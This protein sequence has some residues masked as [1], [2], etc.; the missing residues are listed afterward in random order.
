[1]VADEEVVVEQAEGA[2][3][4]LA[5]EAHVLRLDGPHRLAVR[6]HRLALLEVFRDRR[7]AAL[8]QAQARDQARAPDRVRAR[9]QPAGR[10]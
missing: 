2:R 10:M 7:V 9:G 6:Q 3:E 1:V 5:A 8:D 4:W